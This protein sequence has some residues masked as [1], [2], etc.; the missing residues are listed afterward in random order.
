MTLCQDVEL[1]YLSIQLSRTTLVIRASELGYLLFSDCCRYYAI[2]RPLVYHSTITVRTAGLMIVLAWC[3]P[4]CISF[5][6]IFLGWYTTP[7]NLRNSLNLDL[8]LKTF[9]DSGWITTI[10]RGSGKVDYRLQNLASI[11][12]HTRTWS[13]FNHPTKK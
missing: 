5:L 12:G 1:K 11:I 4:S 2:A 6:P 10:F 3:T 7:E 8:H 9:G 13:I